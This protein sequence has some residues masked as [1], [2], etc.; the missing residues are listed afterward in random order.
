[1]GSKYNPPDIMDP[2]QLAQFISQGFDT[3]KYGNAYD[4]YREVIPHLATGE[5]PTKSHYAFGWIIYYA[6]HQ[7]PDHEI[8]E[9]KRMLA[10]YLQLRVAKPHKLHS[11]ILTEA[12]RLY[13]NAKDAAFNARN[14]QKGKAGDVPHFSL[15]RFSELWDLRNL[16]PGDW[17]RKIYEGKEMSSTVEKFITL[18]VDEIE[19]E[20]AI[21]SP[22]FME[23][24]ERA[25]M[26]YRDSSNLMSQRAALH[27]LAGEKEPAKE[28]LRRA[29]LFAPGK[30]FLWSRLAALYSP[31][32][33]ARKH[34]AL[35]YKALRAPG[36]EQFKGRI[37]L[38]LAQAL[39]LKGMH[40]N[41]LW[42][43]NKVKETYEANGWHTPKAHKEAMEKIPADTVAENPEGLYKRFEGV[44]DS[45]IYDVLPS[46]K[47]TKTYHKNP[48]PNAAPIGR[49]GYGRPVVAW[50]VTDEAG[51]NYWLQPHR[52]GI[53]PDLPLGTPLSIRLHNSRPVKAELLQ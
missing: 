11:M 39:I 34:V 2:Q 32:E 18:Y 28:L 37:R 14:S 43:L 3:A 26:E 6:L 24:I 46:V 7:Q 35:L 50:R 27:Q 52:F 48:D 36:Q 21:P 42:E 15:V 10:N 13:R 4:I 19:N 5:I 23:V 17:T 30:P 29:L 38:S 33:D 31:E 16:R 41:A 47:V 40:H 8:A 25:M 9:R 44:A 20:R 1:M 49:K 51:N 12:M 53:Q 22:A 45:E